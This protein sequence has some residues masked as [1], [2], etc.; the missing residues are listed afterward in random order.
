[1]SNV[2]TYKSSGVDIDA[3]DSLIT[4]IKHSLKQQKDPHL[5]SSLGGFGALF[6]VPEGYRQPILIPVT[7][8]VGTKLKLAGEF[9]RHKTIGIDL[10]AMCVNDI[11]TTGGKPLFFLDYFAT[12]KLEVNIATEV[13]EGIVDG[14]RL[15]QC[16]LVGGET[17]EMPGIYQR[18]DYDL[19]GFAVGIAEKDSILTTDLVESD[20]VLLGIASS[21][22]HSNGYSMV[23]HVLD[24]HA[25]NA[26]EQ[27]LDGTPLVDIFLEPTTIYVEAIAALQKKCSIHAICHVTGGGITDN[28][29]R[30]LPKDMGA[31]IDLTQ[32]K[33][34]SIFTWLQEHSQA[35]QEEM[36]RTFNCGI[37]MIISLSKQHAVLAQRDFAATTNGLLHHRAYFLKTHYRFPRHAVNIAVLISGRRL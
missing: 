6:A 37:G 8:G 1:M 29:P 27:T 28:L 19:A 26:A 22:I 4:N 20:D 36:L 32:W 7:D 25:I 5:L 24:H 10:V 2:I 23:R 18:G 3:A 21:G 34:A 12:S 35:S 13:I 17:A 16:S 14:C 31:T 11:I 33:R 15:A 30:V 9:K